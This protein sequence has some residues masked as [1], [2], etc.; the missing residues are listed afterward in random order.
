MEQEKDGRRG[1]GRRGGLSSETSPARHH[2]DGKLE[3]LSQVAAVRIIFGVE[4]A[5]GP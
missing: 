1:M 3:I 5:A 4:V 2:L